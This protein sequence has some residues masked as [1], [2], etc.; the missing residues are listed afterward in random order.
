MGW[1][2][3][4][5]GQGETGTTVRDYSGKVKVYIPPNVDGKVD[6]I[7]YH[8]GSGSGQ[9]AHRDYDEIDAYIQTHPNQIVIR[10]NLS[11]GDEILIGN[12]LT[13]L[14]SEGIKVGPIH[15]IGHSQGQIG[16]VN[17]AA[18]AIDL[19]YT[20][21]DVVSLDSKEAGGK[22]WNKQAE[23]QKLAEN[24]TKLIAFD[25]R[26][27]TKGNLEKFL[28]AGV[29]TLFVHMENDENTFDENHAIINEGT[30]KN[31]II[32]LILGEAGAT[33]SELPGFEYLY[34]L[35]DRDAEDWDDS[36]TNAEAAAFISGK[37]STEEKT[38]PQATQ[39][40]GIKSKDSDTEYLSDEELKEELS[41]VNNATEEA[42]E[43][44][45]N[46]Q[47]NLASFFGNSLDKLIGNS[48]G[49]IKDVLRAYEILL[50]ASDELNKKIAETNDAY[51][52]A[53]EEFLGSDKELN[54]DDLPIFIEE[55]ESIETE[56]AMLEA[57]NATLALI[58]ETITKFVGYDEDGN[59][60]YETE[61]NPAYDAAQE[62]IRE[63]Q[64]RISKVLTP[65]LNELNRLIDKIN[66]LT[67]EV[68]P[69]LDR[70]LDAMAEE[71]S[72]FLNKVS[73][74]ATSLFGSDGVD[75]YKEYKLAP[76]GTPIPGVAPDESIWPKDS[77]NAGTAPKKSA[78]DKIVK[79]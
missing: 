23:A 3:Y 7:A 47:K 72:A 66:K 55:K 65:A 5:I 69:A 59:P 49:S 62:K 52:K 73:Q 14:S 33:L 21:A 2:E 63:N 51:I 9:S 45:L 37:D 54:T 22:L 78:S 43:Q 75:P 4:V 6:I 28:Q 58:P 34:E 48:W 70:A 79:L 35:Y 24:G 53:L 25:Q 8:P 46:A 56:I 68:L 60:V 29:K 13:D 10:S 17:M 32:P 26:S 71:V 77:E 44:I 42:S 1:S 31:G 64:E 61:H 27:D 30:L 12:I 76:D 74:I 41:A 15:S 40:K 18:R 57:E 39:L 20:V 36:K 19:G 38:S 50:G 11:S 67:N 16:A